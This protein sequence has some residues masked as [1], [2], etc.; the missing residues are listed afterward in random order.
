MRVPGGR[1]CS[2]WGHP[3][4]GVDS[5]AELRAHAA[6]G[7]HAGRRNH[8]RRGSG[9]YVGGLPRRATPRVWRAS[10]RGRPLVRRGW[11]GQ[12]TPLVSHTVCG[13]RSALGE[14]LDLRR[15]VGV[16]QHQAH[17]EGV[18]VEGLWGG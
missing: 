2:G 17:Y 16:E 12:V 1:S 9:R 3:S 7:S 11:S 8:Q 18:S 6:E 14:V 5:A 13:V 15:E 4:T 10:T